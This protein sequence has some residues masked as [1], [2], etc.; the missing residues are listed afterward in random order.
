MHYHLKEK[1]GDPNSQWFMNKFST[2]DMDEDRKM[3]DNTG[4][5]EENNWLVEL[6][7]VSLVNDRQSFERMGY[8]MFAN[9]AIY[10]VFKI[11]Q[12][13]KVT[14]RFIKQPYETRKKTQ[15]RPRRLDN[16]V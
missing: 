4:I 14:K 10:T 2:A 11:T 12:E 1:V 13:A 6:D 7:V 15:F 16:R 5:L 8:A 9:H 3:E